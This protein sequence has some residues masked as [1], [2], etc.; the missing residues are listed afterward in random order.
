MADEQDLSFIP[1]QDL[2][3]ELL[4]RYD[5][6]GIVALKVLK[7][8]EEQHADGGGSYQVVRRWKGNRHTVMGL[9]HDLQTCV[10]Q[11][12][13]EDERETDGEVK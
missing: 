12:L 3:Q 9:L 10:Q 4:S 6:I 11:D 8:L 5:H 1:T 13:E 2:L 7:V